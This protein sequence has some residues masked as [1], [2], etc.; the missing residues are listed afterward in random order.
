[1]AT[2]LCP[3]EINHFSLG[4]GKQSSRT[5]N[6]DVHLLTA[7]FGSIDS[8]GCLYFIWQ[9]QQQQHH[10]RINRGDPIGDIGH[11]CERIVWTPNTEFS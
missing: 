8:V 3:I 5:N 9:H 10:E 11:V 4:M 7:Q 2:V 6:N 1:M